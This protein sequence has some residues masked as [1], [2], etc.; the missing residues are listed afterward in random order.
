MCG[1]IKKLIKIVLKMMYQLMSFL[2][3]DCVRGVKMKCLM[4]SLK[5]AINEKNH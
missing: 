1:V 4:I 3:L 5:L 2:Y